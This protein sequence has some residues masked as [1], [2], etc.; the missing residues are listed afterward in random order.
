M[1]RGINHQNILDSEDYW[2]MEK[3]SKNGL[4]DSLKSERT[5]RIDRGREAISI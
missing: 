5:E 2:E 4:P 1:L 3:E